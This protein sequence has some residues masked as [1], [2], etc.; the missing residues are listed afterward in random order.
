MKIFLHFLNKYVLE[1]FF[2]LLQF[3]RNVLDFTHNT[4]HL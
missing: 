4:V 1:D 2:F 3:G